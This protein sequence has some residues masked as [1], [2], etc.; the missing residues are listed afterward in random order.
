ML[1]KSTTTFHRNLINIM[2]YIKELLGAIDSQRDHLYG[3]ESLIT[4]ILLSI[5]IFNRSTSFLFR[6]SC[7]IHHEKS[8]GGHKIQA[9]ILGFGHLISN[10]IPSAQLAKRYLLYCLLVA[11]LITTICSANLMISC[12]N[13][14][15]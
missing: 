3:K 14:Y 11:Q 1:C 7:F 12:L 6:V 9:P 10:N 4:I 15:V 2:C 8:N 5:F 13:Q